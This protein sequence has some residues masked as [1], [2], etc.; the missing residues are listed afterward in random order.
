ML[1]AAVRR[2]YAGANV[3]QVITHAGVSRP[4]FY[5][6][7]A[8]KDDCF[9]AV[10]RE[11]SGQLIAQI[12]E[13]VSA[14]AP[15]HAVQAG[16]RALILFAHAKP[17]RAR[18]FVNETMAGGSDALDQRDRLIGQIEQ[19][20]EQ[21][22]AGV[23]PQTPTPDLPTRALL[24]GVCGLLAPRLRRNEYDLT[25]LAEQIC[26]WIESYNRPSG[27]HRWRTLEP[28]VPLTPPQHVSE[29]ALRPPPLLPRGRPSLSPAEIARHQRERIVHATAEV[30]TKKG[31]TRATVADITATAGVDRR[32]FYTHFH[33]KQ[34]AFLAAYE[35]AF[36]QMMAVC[37]S[38]F[39][40]R[41]SWPERIWESLRAGTHFN[42]SYPVLA[43]I[44]YVEAQ[45]VGS[46]AI[47]RV[48]D[49]RAAFNIFVQE[50][51][52]HTSKS[53]SPAA[54]DAISATIF[55]I[56]Y[57]QVR[58]RQVEMLPR[59][60]PHAT[61][62][63]LAPFLGPQQANDFIDA[64]ISEEQLSQEQSSPAAT[65]HSRHAARDHGRRRRNSQG[66]ACEPDVETV[67]ADA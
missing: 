23:S 34:Q 12:G 44:G 65:S 48:D 39:F 56:G 25:D 28:G 45:A 11:I 54:F 27:Q 55:E 1:L 8:D 42:A 24:G 38:A 57:H 10:H 26:E 66:G 14:A 33:N 22:R 53:P 3:A 50:G 18:F 51:N 35:L 49:S 31:Y 9:L 47:Q 17:E 67:S 5:E 46:P 60:T 62:L 58:R 63:V 6:Y 20:I 2:G 29:L 61:Y 13:A 59:L 15:E 4:T 52:R 43:H 32:V 16:V 7:F 30:A 36:Q 37:A 21:A 41:D 64:K 19:V 40:S